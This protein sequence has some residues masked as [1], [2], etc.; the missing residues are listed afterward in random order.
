MWVN[1]FVFIAQNTNSLLIKKE[2]L[3]YSACHNAGAPGI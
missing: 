1:T 2:I 3:R